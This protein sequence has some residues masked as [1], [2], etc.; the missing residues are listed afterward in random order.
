MGRLSKLRYKCHSIISSFKGEGKLPL[1]LFFG[2]L[3]VFFELLSRTPTF[4]LIRCKEKI[5]FLLIFLQID[6]THEF[7]K[8]IWILRSRIPAIPPPPLSLSLSP[9]FLSVSPSLSLTL[10]SHMMSHSLS[11]NQP[12]PVHVRHTTCTI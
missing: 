7:L 2:Y 4:F 8:K 6:L 12:P 10:Y 9:L 11:K 5:Q 1:P 3:S